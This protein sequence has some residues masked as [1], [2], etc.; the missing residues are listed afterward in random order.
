M[1]EYLQKHKKENY[2]DNWSTPSNIYNWFMER[3]Y[4]DPC[5][6]YSTIDP[7][8]YHYEDKMFIN[9]P[10]SNITDF[11]DMGIRL[12]Q[13]YG[14]EIVFLVPAR[15]DTKWFHKIYTYGCEV[16]FIQGRLKFGDSKQAAPFPSI[17]IILRG[18]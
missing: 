10:Y 15:V 11:I 7:L 16:R 6:L 18:E 3:G 13:F 17:Y 1:K 8:T 4:H 9:P 5:P 12:H 2:T 14:K